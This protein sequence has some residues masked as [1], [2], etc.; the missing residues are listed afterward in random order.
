MTTRI[1]NPADLLAWAVQTGRVPAADHAL[2][3]AR[4][5]GPAGDVYADELLT[6]TTISWNRTTPPYPVTR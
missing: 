4:L 6:G 2:W 3:T 5:A 1:S